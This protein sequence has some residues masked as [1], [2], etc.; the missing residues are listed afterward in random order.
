MCCACINAVRKPF[1]GHIIGARDWQGGVHFRVTP[2]L[3]PILHPIPSTLKIIIKNSIVILFFHFNY[4]IGMLLLTPNFFRLKLLT[5]SPPTVKELF[6]NCPMFL[7]SLIHIHIRFLPPPLPPF[8]NVW[9]DYDPPFSTRLENEEWWIYFTCHYKAV[10]HTLS[11]RDPL[12]EGTLRIP[13]S[14]PF[15]ASQSGPSIH[16]SYASSPKHVFLFS[17]F[18]SSSYTTQTS[19]IN[20]LFIQS[21]PGDGE[22][23]QGITHKAV[24]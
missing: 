2:S 8:F 7:L 20:S 21:E 14:G 6:R 12:Y 9:T 3:F 24:S 17:D 19:I 10:A 1:Y 15:Q 16:P 4:S 22:V 13:P 11:P 18:S 23:V 5:Y